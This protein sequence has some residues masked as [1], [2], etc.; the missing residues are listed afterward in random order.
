MPAGAD[1]A[2]LF[3]LLFLVALTAAVWLWMYITRVPEI[4][5]RRLRLQDLASAGAANEA[6]K[7]VAGPSD[8]LINLFEIPVLFYVLVILLYVTAAT[9]TGYLL[10]AWGF[11][12]LRVLH[13]LIHSSYNQ[14]MHRF[15]VY[16]L[17]TLVL[18]GMWAR[19]GWYLLTN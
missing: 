14:V 1:P 4:R 3:P 19:F 7:E 9:D 8:N 18:W 5:R 2:I 16:V 15:P 10:A 13:S 17:S 11:V 12:L 6:L